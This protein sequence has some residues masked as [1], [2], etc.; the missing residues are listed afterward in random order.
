MGCNCK[1]AQYVRRAKE[2]GGYNTE[3]KEGISFLA[4]L[5]VFFKTFLV[6]GVMAII[7]PIVLIILFIIKLLGIKKGIRL[8]KLIKIK[9]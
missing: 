3:V 8:F 2:Y 6:L 9:I 5:K 7:T 1:A 4:K